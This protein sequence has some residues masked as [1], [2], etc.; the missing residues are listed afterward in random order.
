MKNV[1]TRYM[2]QGLVKNIA[3]RVGNRE[4]VLMEYY[5]EGLDEQ[6]LFD[7]ASVTKIFC[8]TTLFLIALDQ[9]KLSP[10]QR[11]GEFFAC[12]A[13]KKEITLFQLLTHSS[14]FGAVPLW[15]RPAGCSA[16]EFIL[17]Y[18]LAYPTGSRVVYNCAGFVLLGKILEKTFEM[19]LDQA[20]EEYIK[21]PLGLKVSG[22]NAGPVGN[23]VDANE[24][25]SAPGVTSNET[26]LELGGVSGNAGLFANIEELTAFIK[27]LQN[28]GAPLYSEAV[29]DLA[30]KNYT[31]H[32]EESRGMGFYYV[33]RRSEMMAPLFPD[34]AIGHRGHTGQAVFCDPDTGLYAIILTDATK[35]VHALGDTDSRRVHALHREIHSAIKE[36][37]K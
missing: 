24:G 37:L 22:Y 34:G 9:K 20:F 12:P 26:A 30:R 21:K 23:I 31:P 5:S 17:N 1:I 10:A 36:N 19:G 7:V 2:A 28:R 27:V 16:E 11:L 14:G 32:L 13:D 33:D 35:C 4:G 3:V 15:E 29:F 18:P 25:C 6:T 8:T